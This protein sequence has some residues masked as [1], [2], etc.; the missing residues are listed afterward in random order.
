VGVRGELTEDPRLVRARVRPG[1]GDLSRGP[2]MS[3]DQAVRAVAGGA[4]LASRLADEGAEILLCGD[5]GIGN[6]TPAACLVACFTGAHAE[7]VTGPGAGGPSGHVA[8]KTALVAEALRRNRPDP[9]RPLDALALVGGLEHAAQVGLMLG[10]AR[11]GRPVVLDGVASAAAALVAA[12][13]CPPVLGYLVAGH[14]S[15]EPAAGRALEHLGLQPLLDLELRL[16]EGTGGLL[17]L[18]LVRAAARVLRDVAL[19]DEVAGPR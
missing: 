3:R 14:R 19:I 18:P 10:G 16:G 2:A 1:T 11:A 7:D 6:T 5:M 12:A 4:A 15:S 8:R 9:A 17:A 13:L